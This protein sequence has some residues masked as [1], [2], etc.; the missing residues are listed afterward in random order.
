[1]SMNDEDVDNHL[2]NVS[3]KI[4]RLNVMDKLEFLEKFI[5]DNTSKFLKEKIYEKL[6]SEN[7][8]LD[9]LRKTNSMY[10]L[11][12]YNVPGVWGLAPVGSG[13]SPRDSSYLIKFT[14]LVKVT[15][16]LASFWLGCMDMTKLDM[17]KNRFFL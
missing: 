13:A 3:K 16:Y 5:S 17:T 9:Y 10:L 2:N 1:M 11:K 15:K 4:E 12:L 7:Y 14:L 8:I 6:K